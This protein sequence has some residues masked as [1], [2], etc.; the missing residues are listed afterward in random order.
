MH[1]ILAV[2]SMTRYSTE[3][4]VR[5]IAKAKEATDPHVTVLYVTEKTDLEK[6]KERTGDQGFLGTIPVD[7]FMH[8]VL[9]EH[10][11]LKQER[12]LEIGRRLD[13]EHISYKVHERQGKYSDS[14]IREV[15][16]TLYDSVFL[17]KPQRSC[18]ERLFLGSE[19]MRVAEYS[20][21]T[22]KSEINIVE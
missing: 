11:K 2:F 21:K 22:R 5:V 15:E 18:I 19:V 10:E 8:S 12:L 20:R 4:L 6:L 13:E 14:V 16:Q 17:P 3:L 1:T 9:G 7:R